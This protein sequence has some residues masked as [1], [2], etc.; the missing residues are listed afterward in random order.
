MTR[1]IALLSGLVCLLHS[2]F[3][4]AESP[5]E[6]LPSPL[7]LEQALALADQSHPDL[8]LAD[9]TLLRARA[10]LAEVEAEDDLELKLTGALSAVDPSVNAVDQSNNDSWARLRL[11]KL[12]YDFGRTDRARAVAQANTQGRLWRLLDTRQTRRL[13]VMARYFDVLLADLEYARD[14]EAM[15]IA[16]VR[17]DRGHSRSELGQLS[18]IEL[19][20]LENRYQQSRRKLIGSQN[21]QRS[22]RSLLA[23]T[24]NRLDDLP[25]ELEYPPPAE[26]YQQGE[27]E[28]LTQRVLDGNPVLQALRAEVE[29]AMQGLRAAE[30]ED[31]PEIR[32]ELAA[33]EYNRKLGG[34]NPLSASL[35]LEIPLYTGN[36]VDAKKALQRARLQEQRANLSRYEL[37]LRQQILEHWLELQRLAIEREELLVTS[38]FR[39]L[40]QERSRALYDLEAASDL[41]DSM[42]QIADLYLM[43]AENDFQSRLLQARLNALAGSLIPTETT[44]NMTTEER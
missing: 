36:R 37:D 13:E 17:L 41:G 9:A 30:A 1:L 18:D 25:A 10:E 8:D 27:I 31:N 14:N 40:T 19:L 23:L 44:N 26:P 20:E 35:I 11:S 39:D 43:Q 3:N 28:T 16:F 6:P 38:D 34:R 24:L 32:G 12:L 29:S 5:L 22:S 15:S 2:A 7:T 42:V 33:A 21:R 4:L